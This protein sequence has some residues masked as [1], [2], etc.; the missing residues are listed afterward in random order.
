MFRDSRVRSCAG[1]R[2][3]SICSV[4]AAISIFCGDS[5]SSVAFLVFFGRGVME[6]SKSRRLIWPKAI[7]LNGNV[8]IEVMP[9]GLGDARMAAVSKPSSPSMRVPAFEN[10]VISVLFVIVNS[11][12]VAL[13]NKA[14]LRRAGSLRPSKSRW[15]EYHSGDSCETHRLPFN[16]RTNEPADSGRWVS[17]F[18]L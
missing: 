1:A 6:S 2:V 13:R 10:L 16:Y 3:V 7:R 17:T 18:S 15:Q 12:R 9:N 11:L 5:S 8:P 4:S 14:P